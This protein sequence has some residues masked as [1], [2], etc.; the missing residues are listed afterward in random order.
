MIFPA[1]CGNIVKVRRH[2]E[3]ARGAAH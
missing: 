2:R 1:S 3:K